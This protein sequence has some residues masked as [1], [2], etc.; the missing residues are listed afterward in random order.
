MKA[1]SLWQPWATLWAAGLKQ[2][3][4]RSKLTH[5]R[6]VLL[7]H[8]AKLKTPELRELCQQ[9]PF[10]EALEV[11]GYASYDDLPFGCLVGQAEIVDCGQ[12]ES[13]KNNQ[14]LVN[15]P[16]HYRTIHSAHEQAFGDYSVG[17]WIYFAQNHMRYIRP[18]PLCGQQGMWEVSTEEFNRLMV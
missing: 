6:G 1:R 8:A 11:L 16:K 2:N 9:E 13:I 17:R 15:T 12:V 3:E 5:H 14:V 7:I 18:A 4:T 10:R